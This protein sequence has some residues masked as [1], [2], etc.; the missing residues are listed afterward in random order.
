MANKNKSENKSFQHNVEDIV[1]YVG[2]LYDLYKGQKCTVKDRSKKHIREYY[3]V[4][5]L[6]GVT[7]E[8]TGTVLKKIEVTSEGEVIT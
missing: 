3:K 5:F 6:D 2:S 4:Q 8:I 1:I 7:H